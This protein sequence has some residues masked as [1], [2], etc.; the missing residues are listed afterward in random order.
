M[1]DKDD[2][3]RESERPEARAG[4]GDPFAVAVAST[5]MPMLLTDVDGDDHAIVYV[6]DAFLKMTGYNR[7]EIMG[8][9]CL[10]LA[11][12]ETSEE[13]LR[14][15]QAALTE[16]TDEVIEILSYRKDGTPFWSADFVGPVRNEDGKLTNSFMTLID[17]TEK[18]NA[19]T[20]LTEAN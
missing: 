13:A 10:F 6:N 3:K 19:E 2:A 11:G 17:M 12:E 1:S 15:L 4:S 16:G 7:D 20:Q 9:N 8:R 14:T 5:R 18:K